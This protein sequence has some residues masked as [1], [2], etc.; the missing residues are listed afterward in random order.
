MLCAAACISGYRLPEVQVKS[1]RNLSSCSGV[2]QLILLFLI[3]Q[4]LLKAGVLG[5]RFVPGG[6]PQ[7][8]L[9]GNVYSHIMGLPQAPWFAFAALHFYFLIAAVQDLV[10]ELST[11]YAQC[12]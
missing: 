4:S 2:K 5:R 11:C 8:C 6:M 7:F 9:G 10:A 12:A 3:V 1:A